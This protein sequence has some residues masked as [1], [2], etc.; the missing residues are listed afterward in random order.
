MGTVN[1]TKCL[2]TPPRQ[3]KKDAAPLPFLFSCTSL[4]LSTFC[5]HPHSFV[6]HS[7]LFLNF[8]SLLFFCSL[9]FFSAFPISISPSSSTTKTT[10]RLLP[11]L[12]STLHLHLSLCRHHPKSCASNLKFHGITQVWGHTLDEANPNFTWSE[13][14]AFFQPP[15]RH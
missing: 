8:P 7:D 14:Q 11:I 5:C 10:R 3:T 12:P 9:F 6:Q 13:F 15:V 2:Q 4:N 1:I